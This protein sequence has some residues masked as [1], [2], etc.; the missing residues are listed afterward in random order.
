MMRMSDV[1]P[2]A[3]LCSL[4]I[5]ASIATLTLERSD[6]YNALNVQLISEINDILD[7]TALR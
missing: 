2:S 1:K 7:W 5:D 3:E 4:S 6:V